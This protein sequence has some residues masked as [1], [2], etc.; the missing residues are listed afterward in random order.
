[1]GKA[2]GPG[3]G[4][5]RWIRS[6]KYGIKISSA[7][8]GNAR[9]EHSLICKKPLGPHE[10]IPTILHVPVRGNTK[11]RRNLRTAVDRLQLYIIYTSTASDFATSKPSKQRGVFT[12]RTHLVDASP[13]VG[14]CMATRDDLLFYSVS[15]D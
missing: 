1:M 11:I 5:R 6:K 7:R 14:Y 3:A 2:G 4:I 9:V 10:S 15:A 13:Y 8:D 12:V